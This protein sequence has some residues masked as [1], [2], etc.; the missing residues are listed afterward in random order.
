MRSRV[1]ADGERPEMARRGCVASASGD[2]TRRR[3]PSCRSGCSC[4]GR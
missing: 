4:G 2:C 1:A 3:A